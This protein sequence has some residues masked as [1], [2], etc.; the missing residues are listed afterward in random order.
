MKMLRMVL[1]GLGVLV[2][3]MGLIWIGQ[4]T[5][6][7]PYPRQSFMISQMPWA[8]RG[9]VLMVIGAILIWMSRRR[10]PIAPP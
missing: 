10:P 3:L 1:R 8:Y 9:A 5:G 4:G 2:M 6:V 7:F